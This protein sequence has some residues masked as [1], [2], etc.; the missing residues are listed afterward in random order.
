MTFLA[1][2]AW[3][4]GDSSKLLYASKVE[5]FLLLSSIPWYVYATICLT[6]HLL[7]GIWIDCNCQLLQVKLLWTFVYRFLCERKFSFFW[8]KCP[9]VQVLGW[10]VIAC[11][12]FSETSKLLSRV[13]ISFA[14]PI[15]QCMCNSHFYSDFLLV[16]LSSRCAIGR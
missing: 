4:P 6:R 8:G 15:S 2:S 5:S 14:F 9:R 11:L 1:R 13:A 10:M 7:N 3:F 12:V 16:F